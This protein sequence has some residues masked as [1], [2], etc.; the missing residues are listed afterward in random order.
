VSEA[1]PGSPGYPAMVPELTDGVVRLR[2]LAESD[3]EALLEQAVDPE[4]VAWTTVPVPS[5]LDSSRVFATELVPDGWESGRSWLFAVEAHDPEQP[6]AGARFCGSVELRPHGSGRAEIAYGAHPWARG[7]GLLERAC[8]LLLE[9]GFEQRRLR[10]VIWWAHRGNFASRKLAWRLGFAVDGTVPQWLEQRGELRDAWVGHLLAGDARQPRHAW[11]DA[12]TLHG[13]RVTLRGYRDHDVTR[14]HQACSDPSTAHWLTQMPQ[15]YTRADAEEFVLSRVEQLAEGTSVHWAVVDPASDRL[16]GNI[17]IFDL[18]PG[19]QA[20]IGYW[21]HPDSRGR[22]VMTEACRLVVRHGFLPVEDGGLG[23]QRLQIF[24][25]AGNVASQRVIERNGFVRT[26]QDR[27]ET[28]LR[29]GSAV[30]TIGYDL[31]LAEWSAT[32]AAGSGV[33]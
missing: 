29:D 19:Q 31:L 17:G 23:L 1:A 14:I 15:P 5:S 22:G 12:P 18:R 4:M 6:E 8:R 24:A 25:A 32:S 2:A 9:W 30:D 33:G 27:A 10:T 21:T 11:L 7:R 16:V 28:R 20:E 3:V 13:E 26:G